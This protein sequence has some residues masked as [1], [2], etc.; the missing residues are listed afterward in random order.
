MLL[1]G[2]P[3]ASASTPVA[4]VCTGSKSI[5]DTV[6][7]LLD[8]HTGA[9][10]Q[11]LVEARLAL[12]DGTRPIGTVYVDSFGMRYLEKSE[13]DAIPGLS[14]AAGDQR[15]RPLPADFTF[16]GGLRLRACRA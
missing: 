16:T 13:N 4:P 2:A 12:L 8:P 6:G 15:I 9:R 7:I 3:L 14:P 1:L 5:G 10:E 11:T